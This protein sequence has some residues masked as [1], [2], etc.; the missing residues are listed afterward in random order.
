MPHS[1][2]SMPFVS[3]AIALASVIL[4]VAGL[5]LGRE[6]LIPF[7][8]AIL[9]TFLL[10]PLVI[11]VRRW[12][13]GHV[14]A[15]AVVGSAAAVFAGTL[16]AFV[17]LQLADLVDSLPSYLHNA[18]DR[19][20]SLL[21]P[22]RSM[23]GKLSES[24]KEITSTTAAAETAET[25]TSAPVSAKPVDTAE[26]VG[27]FTAALQTI[28]APFVLFGIVAIL[29]GTMLIQGSDLRDR[30]LRLIGDTQITLTTKALD[31]VA[32]RVS[33]YLLTQTL[34]NGGAGAVVAAAL[35]LIGVPS[36]LLW[37]LLWALLRFLPFVGPW[38]GALMPVLTAFGVSES[39]AQPLATIALF[40][41]IE[42]I[43]NS[44]LEPW[45]YGSGTGLSPLAVIAAAIFW[46]WLWGWVGLLLATPMTVCLA[47]LGRYVDQLSFLHI[48]LGDEP[49]LKPS[50]QLYQRLLSGQYDESYKLIQHFAQSRPLL[51]VFDQIL[52]PA[53]RRI[54]ADRRAGLIDADAAARGYTL[55]DRAIHEL[56]QPRIR[57]AIINDGRPLLVIPA[58]D[59][60]DVLCGRML[61]R[62]L[63]DRGMIVDL[64]E[65]G[66]FAAEHA[67]SVAA[68]APAAVLISA[69][70]RTRAPHLRYLLRRIAER[71]PDTMLI[72]G[73][74]NADGH[75]PDAELRHFDPSG[76]VLVTT[77]PDAADALRFAQ[78]RDRDSLAAPATESPASAPFVAP[79]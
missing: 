41:V 24:V 53:L 2:A 58:R 45:L 13:L 32:E 54:D 10:N 69:L 72:G 12:G 78:E 52:V 16:V 3:R 34:L 68:R 28:A 64:S 29:T 27:F 61:Q 74:W 59:G 37:A 19:L 49:V 7:T 22:I 20:E 44:I 48:L 11:R 1:T 30:L 31:D 73:V 14:A 55:I 50:T 15:V 23:A 18:Q 9:V 57:P 21:N 6:V 71:N 67:E 8:L 4:V 42:T 79:A 77:F 56:P 39:W 17:A 35:M 38:L 26:Q 40:I 60:A 43:L 63:A 65:V 75:E 36:A 47:V 70:D 5:Y 25:A 33:R 76:A 46:A 51:A 66:Q 62:F